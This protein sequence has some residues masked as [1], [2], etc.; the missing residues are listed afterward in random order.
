[1]SLKTEVRKITPDEARLIMGTNHNNR[2]V[3]RAVVEKYV[4][5]MENGAWALNGE[6]IKISA[7]GDLLDGQHRLLACIEADIPFETVF[8]SGVPSDAQVAMDTGARRTFSDILR[9]KGESNVSSLATAVESALCWDE[10][11]TPAHRGKQHSNAERLAWL[12]AN[13]DIRY[14]VRGWMPLACKPLR[15][16]MSAGA[17]F[18]LRITRIDSDD[19]AEFVR[20][21]KTGDGL[22]EKDPIA[23]LRHWLLNAAGSKG[24]YAREEYA[25][26]GV[27]AWNFWLK[28]KEVGHLVWRSGGSRREDFPFL[29]TPD[30]QLYEE[31]ITDPAYVPP[32]HATFERMG[33]TPKDEQPQKAAG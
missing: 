7:T 18:L 28:G 31:I 2:K 21:L 33:F 20:L 19:A 29:S 11:G 5:D 24:K 8:I 10:S 26:V 22:A 13:P 6:A 3:R 23:R 15:F 1:M 17:P 32:G 12:E 9:W 4:R 27:K 16:P 14:A 30:G 25:A